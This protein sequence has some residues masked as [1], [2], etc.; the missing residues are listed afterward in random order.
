M[1]FKRESLIRFYDEPNSW[2]CEIEGRGSHV[3]AITG[4]IGEDLI[5]ALLRHYWKAQKI[6]SHIHSYQCN[7]RKK[8]GKRLDAWILSDSTLYQVEVKNWSGHSL[9]GYNNELNAP[10]K[11][12]EE[13]AKQR[14]KHYFEGVSGLPP[15][16]SKVLIPMSKPTEFS[17]FEVIKLICFWS[18][19]VDEKG[20]PYGIKKFND[21]VLHVFSASAYLRSITDTVIELDMPR[22]EKRLSLLTGLI[23]ND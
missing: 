13:F 15:E 23:S 6:D 10:A 9:G 5:I 21:D 1:K 17:T 20:M 7:Q 3:S 2:S 19:V 8:V 14:W 12:L 4:L 22:A 11:A 18:Y 16:I